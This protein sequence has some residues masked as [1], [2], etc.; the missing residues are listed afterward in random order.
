MS[1]LPF[2]LA[3]LVCLSEL[4]R[5]I[6]L[7]LIPICL[8]LPGVGFPAGCVRRTGLDLKFDVGLPP[9]EPTPCRHSWGGSLYA[10]QSPNYLLLVRCSQIFN[11]LSTP[12][13]D[14]DRQGVKRLHRC[15]ICRMR[16]M[17]EFLNKLV[18]GQEM[19]KQHAFSIL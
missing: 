17:R 18:V 10:V 11:I 1:L 4:G 13:I 9:C 19:L 14:T 16:K 12:M 5:G 15:M 8:V 7:V 6:S 3:L 2:C